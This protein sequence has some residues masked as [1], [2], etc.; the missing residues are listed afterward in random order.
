MNLKMHLFQQICAIIMHIFDTGMKL[1]T[2]V[3][4]GDTNIFRLVNCLDSK[5]CREGFIY[6]T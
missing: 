5:V 4:W 6:F 2:I 1:G 3:L